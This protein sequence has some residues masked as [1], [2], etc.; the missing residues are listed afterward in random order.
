M[1][2]QDY[3]DAPDVRQLWAKDQVARVPHECACCKETIQPGE[4]YTSWG[5]LVD[6]A[7]EYSKHHVGAYFYP[8]GCPG[9]GARERAEE[10]AQ[11]AKD[12]ALWNTAVR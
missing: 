10:E 8:S 12:Q 4:R 6:G 3:R 2:E 7:F 1:M 9:I 11:F 5:M